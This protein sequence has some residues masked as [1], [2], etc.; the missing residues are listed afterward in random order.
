MAGNVQTFQ[1]TGVTNQHLK[2]GVQV[3]ACCDAGTETKHFQHLA[4]SVLRDFV[5]LFRFT[6]Q[7][8]LKEEFEREKYFKDDGAR[9]VVI[10]GLTTPLVLFL[11]LVS[12][13][14]KFEALDSDAKNKY[15]TM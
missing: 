10:F 6:L 1:T 12:S 11:S 3:L 8:M 14:P 13:I 7:I 9:F 5:M 4:T 2:I 15:R